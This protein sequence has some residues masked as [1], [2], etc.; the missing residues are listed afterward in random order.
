MGKSSKNLA[1]TVSQIADEY[2]DWNKSGKLW[3][4]NNKDVAKSNAKIGKDIV[5]TL[6]FQEKGNKNLARIS[7]LKVGFS[8]LFLKNQNDTTKELHKQFKENQRIQ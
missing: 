6:K 4:K 2:T 8:R 1:A 3:N 7:K 5:N